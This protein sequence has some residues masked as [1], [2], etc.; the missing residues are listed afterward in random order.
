MRS[1]DGLP[2]SIAGQVSLS[3]DSFDADGYELPRH[4]RSLQE[5]SGFDRRGFS[6]Q[7]Q[8]EPRDGGLPLPLFVR[9]SPVF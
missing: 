7:H 4:W 6:E 8:I 3:Q 5:G 9:R 2:E 1:I